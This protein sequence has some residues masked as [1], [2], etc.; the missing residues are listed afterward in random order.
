M[1]WC[2]QHEGGHL[3]LE[4]ASNTCPE[5][6]SFRWLWIQS[7]RRWGATTRLEPPAPLGPLQCINAVFNSAMHISRTLANL[8]ICSALITLEDTFCLS[9]ESLFVVP[10]PLFWLFPDDIETLYFFCWISDSS[11]DANKASVPH[12]LPWLQSLPDFHSFFITC[13]RSRFCPQASTIALVQSLSHETLLSG[14]PRCHFTPSTQ[15]LLLSVPFHVYFLVPFVL[16]WNQ[17]SDF[18]IYLC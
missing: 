5:I 8:G 13:K 18:K 15:F 16:S 1:K 10:F 4:T 14:H 6:L 9:V 12:L 2:H 11:A 7:S 17:S 3:K